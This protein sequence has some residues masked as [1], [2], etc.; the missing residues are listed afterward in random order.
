MVPCLIRFAAA[1][2][3]CSQSN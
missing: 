3:L 1:V 2:N